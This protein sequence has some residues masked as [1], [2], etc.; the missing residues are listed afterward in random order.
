LED[1]WFKSQPRHP[2]TLTEV[3]SGITKSLQANAR[4]LPLLGQILFNSSFWNRPTIWHG[5][6]WTIKA[7]LNIKN[8]S[9]NSSTLDKG[10]AGTARA[11]WRL[12]GRTPGF[13]KTLDKVR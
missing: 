11:P 7:S 2:T 4:I 8:G 10:E 5:T 3:F 1:A 6:V 13:K 9:P 12:F